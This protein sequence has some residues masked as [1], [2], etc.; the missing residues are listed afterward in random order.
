MLNR[1][2]SLVMCTI[3]NQSILCSRSVKDIN[4]VKNRGKNTTLEKPSKAAGYNHQNEL[5]NGD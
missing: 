1:Y 3:G 4:I 2:N 5:I